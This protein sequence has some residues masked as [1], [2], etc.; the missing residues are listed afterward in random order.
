MIKLFFYYIFT[1]LFAKTVLYQDVSLY[2]RSIFNNEENASDDNKNKDNLL[3]EEDYNSIGSY[4]SDDIPDENYN[5]NYNNYNT[6]SNEK[7][8]TNGDIKNIENL[9]SEENQ[10]KDNYSNDLY[11]YDKNN[12]DDINDDIDYNQ[13]LKGKFVKN[14]NIKLI[15]LNSGYTLNLT[16]NIDKIISFSDSKIK[17]ISCWVDDNNELLADSRVS[18]SVTNY[19]SDGSEDN[20]YWISKKYGILGS[21]LTI[22]NEYIVLLIKCY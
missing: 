19:K 12:N 15:S 1:I 16:L 8:P 4:E 2:A 21:T 11:S 10:D 7:Y 5:Q 9:N 3:E 22:S 14:A 6:D 18:I 17:M 13:P 20:I